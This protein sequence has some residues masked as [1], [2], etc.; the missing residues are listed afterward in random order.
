MPCF[1]Q[2][3]TKARTAWLVPRS[4]V[5]LLFRGKRSVMRSHLMLGQGA[6]SLVA[7]AQDFLIERLLTLRKCQLPYLRSAVCM[8]CY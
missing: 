7:V 1:A 4:T 3:G 2:T 8:T 6:P 5:L